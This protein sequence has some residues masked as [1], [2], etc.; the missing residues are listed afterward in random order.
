MRKVDVIIPTYNREG[1]LRE[2]IA[3]VL[4]QTFRDFTIIVVDDGGEDRAKDVVES[5]QDRRIEYVRNPMN[6]GEARARNIGLANSKADY[7]A[8]LDDDDDWLP[9][10]L[11]SQMDL[12]ESRPAQVGGV[13]AGFTAID[14]RTGATLYDWIPHKRGDICHEMAYENV[15]GTSSTVL[16]RREC[17]ERV[18]RFDES[19][20]YGLDYDMWIRI[21]KEF[22]FD[23]IEKSLVRYHY[24]EGRL[25]NDT[26]RVIAGHE[27]MSKKHEHFFASDKK[28]YSKR[29]ADL[30]FLYRENGD[31][32]KAWKALVR[33]IRIYPYRE[34]GCYTL[35]KPCAAVVLGRRRFHRLKGIKRSVMGLSSYGKINE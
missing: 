7:I 26:R 9:E 30:A 28:S 11:K 15:V 27:A 32:G 21:S 24:H 34:K 12:L 22:H 19:I 25:T 8:F 35:C 5:F 20:P 6:G 29:L 31:I 4:N 10:K 1:F 23:C 17:F 14:S 18:G 2:A 13:Y 16:L 33:A 3:S